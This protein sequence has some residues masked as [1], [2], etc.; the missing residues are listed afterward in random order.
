MRLPNYREFGSQHESGSGVVGDA[1][2]KRCVFVGD[3]QIIKNPREVRLFPFMSQQQSR[4][5]QKGETVPLLFFCKNT[6]GGVRSR[7]GSETGEQWGVTT[8]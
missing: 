3:P 8:T 7:R 4:W 1:G 5:P 2:P 6:T